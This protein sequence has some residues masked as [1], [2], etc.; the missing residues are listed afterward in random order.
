MNYMKTLTE[1]SVGLFQNH[2]SKSREITK[3]N[4]FIQMFIHQDKFNVFISS[5]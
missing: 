2:R 3:F 5:N 4:V 1:L